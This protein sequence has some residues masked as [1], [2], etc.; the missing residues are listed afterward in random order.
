MMSEPSEALDAVLAK[1]TSN[2]PEVRFESMAELII[3]WRDA[4]GR[5]EGVLSPD[6]FALRA[7]P[8]GRLG[9]GPSRALS[10]TVSAAVNPYKGLRAFAEADASD[11]F[12]RDEVAAALLQTVIATRL[13]RGGRPI[14]VGQELTGHA[15]LVPLLRNEGVRV[16]TM[17]PGDRPIV[18][19][20]AGASPGRCDRQR[21]QRSDRVAQA[22][23]PRRALGS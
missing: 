7:V 22:R 19:V 21:H 12:G 11:F 16:A 9:A 18:C 20:A 2:D 6:G 8:R 3:A 1:A 17:V 10:T 13:R 15:G 23:L 4:V 5:P 14:R